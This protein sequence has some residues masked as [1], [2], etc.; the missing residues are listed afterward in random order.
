MDDYQKW[1]YQNCKCI[2]KFKIVH[3]DYRKCHGISL[4]FKL[5]IIN[6]NKLKQLSMDVKQHGSILIE[7]EFELDRKYKE[8]YY[9]KQVT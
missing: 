2:Q 7:F 5:Y 3:L 9:K 8:K 6:L 1:K 4:I